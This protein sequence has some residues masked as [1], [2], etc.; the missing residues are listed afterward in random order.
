MKIIKTL[1]EYSSTIFFTIL[2][3]VILLGSIT[4]GTVYIHKHYNKQ[5]C[6]V[7]N[8]KLQG[9]LYVTSKEISSDETD[10]IDSE[11]VVKEIDKAK[12][13]GNIKAVVLTVNSVGGSM[14][15]GEQIMTAL[16]SLG[17]PSV[18]LVEDVGVSASYYASTGADTIFASKFSDVVDI[19]ITASYVENSKKDINEG[20]TYV[21]LYTGKYKDMFNPDKPMT[22]EEKSIVMKH[23]QSAHDD[24]VAGVAENRN[25]GIDKV[26]EFAI[27][28]TMTAHD[29]LK[30]GFIDQIG[31]MNDV[32]EYL[33]KKIN[34]KVEVCE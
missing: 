31:T 28:L 14:A 27:G 24:F 34:K 30:N 9:K 1:K 16:K 25:M 10:A 23:I 17:K 21:P 20:L 2:S 18:A 12:N 11:S 5:S 13:D 29:A 8:I 4:Y 26:K 6:N 19:G 3:L 22:D 7:A 33:G 32:K 15:G